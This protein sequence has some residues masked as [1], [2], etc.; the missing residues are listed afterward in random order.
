MK[1][2]KGDKVLVTT[3]KDKGKT[4]KILRVLRDQSRV[5]VEGVNVAKK[6]LKPSATNPRGGIVD[7]TLPISVSNVGIVHPDDPKKTSR[8][9][10]ELDKKGNKVRVYRQANNKEID[11]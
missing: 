10:Y 8:I 11:S 2:R 7:E 4:G 5:A 1:L 6:H 9:G 3:G